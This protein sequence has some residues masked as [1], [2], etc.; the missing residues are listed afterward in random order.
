MFS[1]LISV[2]LKYFIQNIKQ[3]DFIKLNG[4]SYV[5][6]DSN[7]AIRTNLNNYYT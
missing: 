7:Y 5:I 3:C 2:D 6:R 1:L 4:M